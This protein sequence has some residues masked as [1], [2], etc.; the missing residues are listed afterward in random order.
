[1]VKVTHEPELPTVAKPVNPCAVVVL[2]PI[3]VLA[4]VAEDAGTLVVK[5]P[6]GDVAFSRAG[7][8]RGADG[9]RAYRDFPAN[10]CMSGMPVQ[11]LNKKANAQPTYHDLY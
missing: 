4:A 2:P 8:T 9:S 1:M 5:R 6:A 10:A 7:S 11:N 3:K